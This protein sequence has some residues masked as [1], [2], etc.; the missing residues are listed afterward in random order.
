MR[1]LARICFCIQKTAVSIETAVFFIAK[2]HT[3]EFERIRY[4]VTIAKGKG[5]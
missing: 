3:A 2:N 4:I 1:P 5:G